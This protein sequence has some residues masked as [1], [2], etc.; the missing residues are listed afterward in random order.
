[1]KKTLLRDIHTT[2]NA[3]KPIYM[4]TEIIS[5]YYYN[6]VKVCAANLRKKS[7][8]NCE[9]NKKNKDFEKK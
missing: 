9:K 5:I 1:M 7:K 6:Y 3:K 2:T 8:R 4:Y